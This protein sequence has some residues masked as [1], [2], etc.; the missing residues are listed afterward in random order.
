MAFAFQNDDD[1]AVNDNDDD[2]P[3]VNVTQLIFVEGLSS[4]WL[5]AGASTRTTFQQVVL[6]SIKQVVQTLT[7]QA[8]LRNVNLTPHRLGQSNPSFPLLM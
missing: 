2:C 8:M 3:T 6:S 4:T 1:D 5:A 7:M